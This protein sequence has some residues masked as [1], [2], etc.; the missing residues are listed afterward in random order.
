MGLKEIG[1]GV[2][3]YWAIILF[4]LGGI[5][6]ASVVY[7]EFQDVKVKVNTLTNSR[8]DD[9]DRLSRMEES[10]DWIKKRLQ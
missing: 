10:L 6:W 8:N 1:D 2:A 7:G 4:I 9:K 5:A 3:K